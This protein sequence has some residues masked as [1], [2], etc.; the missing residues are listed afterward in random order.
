M[1]GFDSIEEL[2]IALGQQRYLTDEGLATVVYLALK[3]RRPLLL[4][5]EPGVGKTELAKALAA[6]S[7]APLIRLQC[8]EGIDVHHALYD[9]D[10]PR[11]LLQLR[12]GGSAPLYSREFLV[13]RPLLDALVKPG[14]V[15]LIDELDRA[16]DEFEAFLLEFLSDFQ[17]TIPE[18]GVIRAEQPPA[19]IITSNRTRDL[20]EALKRR[21]LYHW[22]DHPDLS[23]EVAIARARLPHVGQRL[24][25]QV[26]A[27]VQDLRWLDLYRSPGVGETLDWAEALHVL[28][29]QDIDAA[30]AD[31][32]LGTL[33][34][35]RDDLNHIRHDGLDA[36]L[37]KAQER[38]AEFRG[39]EALGGAA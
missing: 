32:T 28:G 24:T 20:H 8:Y 16:D 10:Y 39:G 29:R 25:E 34:K 6:A 30:T 17:V 33:L 21:C 38:A 9:W 12:A 18:I 31:R 22:I 2:R 15:L 37:E 1:R 23:R 5:G 35:E 26:C 13:G 27:F 3:L 11:Q 4:E 14:V 7:Q 19:V 36:R